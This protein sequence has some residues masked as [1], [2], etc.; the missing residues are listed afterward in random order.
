VLPIV[1]VLLGLAAAPP[2]KEEGTDAIPRKWGSVIDPLKDCTVKLSGGRLRIIIP[3]TPHPY[4]ITG[5]KLTAPQV[6]QD[7]TGDFVA[8]VTVFPGRLPLA[9]KSKH[10]IT[11]SA[12]A[13]L[14]LTDTA[15]AYRAY[16][17]VERIASSTYKR[18]L[19]FA[20]MA[21]SPQGG[22]SSSSTPLDD[23]KQDKPVYF[24][25]ARTGSTIETAS[26]TDGQHWHAFEPVKADWPN[27][28]KVGVFV[29]HDTDAA[30]ESGFV[31]LKIAPPDKK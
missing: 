19:T 14:L 18:V 6:L 4:D 25:L 27:N 11:P 2:P 12:Y 21:H 13:G 20:E 8:T 7:R 29:A 23:P 22:W 26:S 10:G 1:V 28:V 24:R 16:V 9:A 3:A 30:F 17:G 15:G 5:G 31:N